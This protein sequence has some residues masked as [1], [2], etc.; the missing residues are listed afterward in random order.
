MPRDSIGG[1][2]DVV[3][4]I[5]AGILRVGVVCAVSGAPYRRAAIPLLRC[6]IEVASQEPWANNVDA[7]AMLSKLA[8]IVGR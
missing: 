5:V 2:L 3:P 6:R 8:L 7:S 1:A 4:R